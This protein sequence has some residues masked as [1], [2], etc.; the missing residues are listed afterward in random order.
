MSDFHGGRKKRS[1]FEGWYFK[2]Q[3]GENSISLIPGINMNE[4]GKRSAFIQV[5][6]EDRSWHVP[7]AFS[8]FSAAKNKLA[9]RLGDNVFSSDGVEIQLNGEGIAL[10]G[11][12]SYGDLTPLVSD[13]MGPFRFVPFMECHHGVVSLCHNLQGKLCLNGET[14]LLD[15]G[16]GYIEKDWG[17]SFPKRYVWL[18]CNDFPGQRCAVIASVAN[19]PFPGFS[20]TGCIAVVYVEGKEYRLATYKGV[21][22]LQCHEKGVCL[23]QGEYCLEVTIVRRDKAQPLLAPRRGGMA[24]NIHESP[25]CRGRF[26]FSVG[27]KKLLDFIS[28][29]VS[30]EYV[31]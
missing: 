27:Q 23:R 29:N 6:T 9:V 19:I 28:D 20:F 24:R 1:Y 21:K 3:A 22:I 17:H 8:D 18:Q 5:I 13:I 26:R 25:R 14:I 12:V 2:H 31:G 4:T 15:G 11:Q 16:L 30:F 7:F 10:D